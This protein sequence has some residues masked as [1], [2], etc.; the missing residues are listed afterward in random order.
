MKLGLIAEAIEQR[1]QSLDVVGRGRNIGADVAA[2]PLVDLPIVVARAAGMDLHD[3]AIVERSCAPSRSASARGRVPAARRLPVPE[4]TWSKSSAAAA[5]GEVRGARGG[6][7]VVG[8]SAA[9]L[10]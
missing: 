10:P 6:M 3:E 9:Q 1:A 2:V 4:S 8:G 7:A 5:L